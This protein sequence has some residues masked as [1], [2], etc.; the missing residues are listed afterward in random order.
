MTAKRT[1]R[2][3]QDAATREFYA[4]LMK[5]YRGRKPGGQP[6]P[7]VK[8]SL[9]ASTPSIKREL[10]RR[11]SAPLLLALSS[12]LGLLLFFFLYMFLPLFSSPFPSRD[13]S[14]SSSRLWYYREAS[15]ISQAP[16]VVRSLSRSDHAEAKQRPRPQRY[17]PSGINQLN[18][19]LLE[20]SPSLKPILPC[21]AFPS[22]RLPI[23][24][25]PA[26]VFEGR[27][28][29]SGRSLP[30]IN[31]T[32]LSTPRWTSRIPSVPVSSSSAAFGCASRNS[33]DRGGGARDLAARRILTGRDRPCPR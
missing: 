27:P 30:I 28:R 31:S 21:L 14:L 16:K 3:T 22:L 9:T 20:A 10:R 18:A 24:F 4:A 15:D 33:H 6:D 2:L 11:D 29:L 19:R 32:R 12:V 5:T 17:L 8:G 1:A 26:D 25:P 23:L 7:S 13:P